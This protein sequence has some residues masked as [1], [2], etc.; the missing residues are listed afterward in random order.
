ML[1]GQQVRAGFSVVC[2]VRGLVAQRPGESLDDQGCGSMRQTSTY[3][4]PG[5]H[6]ACM[7]GRGKA[8]SSGGAAGSPGGG[9][10]G[11]HSGRMG[12][13][14]GGSARPPFGQRS[15]QEGLH[16]GSCS[17]GGPSEG[18]LPEGAEPGCA[19]RRPG[20]QKDPAGGLRSGP[21]RGAALCLL[22]GL[23][24]PVHDQEVAG[25]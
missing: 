1:Q 4:R 17:G 25:A 8:W 6:A 10:S 11:S 24:C 5:P 14:W 19:G 12:C 7:G 21:K 13:G 2:A 16:S 3:P 20:S 9:R 18:G 22:R 23:C 15:G